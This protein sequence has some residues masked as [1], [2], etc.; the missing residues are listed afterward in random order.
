MLLRT[1]IVAA[2]LILAPVA[3]FAFQC[4]AMMAEIDAALPQ[5]ELSD[6][7]RRRVEDLRAEGEALHQAGDHTASEERLA[8]AKEILG[9]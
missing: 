2:A 6:E 5:A 1:G 7:D 9:L 3:A 4:P 8:E